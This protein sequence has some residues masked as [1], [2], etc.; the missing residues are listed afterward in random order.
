MSYKRLRNAL[1]ISAFAV[2]LSLG[3][4]T[5]YAEESTEAATEA[6][7]EAADSAETHIVKDYF[8]RE[9]EIPVNLTKVAVCDSYNME[10]INVLGAVDTVAGVD[11]FIANDTEKHG[12]EYSLRMKQFRMITMR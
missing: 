5:I 1:L 11:S 3:S 10:C 6:T 7:T 2:S 4:A 12:E 9:V 8:D